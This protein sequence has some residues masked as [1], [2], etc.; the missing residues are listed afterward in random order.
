MKH[1]LIIVLIYQKWKTHGNIYAFGNPG[2]FQTCL[3]V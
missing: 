1:L 2:L 3:Q